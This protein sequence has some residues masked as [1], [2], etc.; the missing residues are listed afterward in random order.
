MDANVVQINGVI[1]INVDVSVG[2]IMYVIMCDEIVESYVEYGEATLYVNT[3]FN[4]EK[5]TCKTQNFYISLAFFKI[6]VALL[7]AR[8]YLLVFDI[9][10]TKTCYCHFTT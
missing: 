2:N 5:A 8:W 7:I 1:I 9:I 10:S 3:N 6:S 4:E